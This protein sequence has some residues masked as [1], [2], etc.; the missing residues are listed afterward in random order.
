M[1]KVISIALALCLCLICFVGCGDSEYKGWGKESLVSI[2]YR[3]P[4]TWEL[5][6]DNVENTK[7]YTIDMPEDKPEVIIANLTKLGDDYDAE[8]VMKTIEK[9]NQEQLSKGAIDVRYHIEESFTICD[10]TVYHFYENDGIRR[11]TYL[12]DGKEGIFR[13]LVK[14]D[15]RYEF[16]TYTEE[17]QLFLDSIV[18]KK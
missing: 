8:S 9:E 12:F 6:N 1:K 7:V 5:T 18:I 15:P 2:T 16:P 13:I 17:F 10:E 4:P 14:Y 11:E 3:I